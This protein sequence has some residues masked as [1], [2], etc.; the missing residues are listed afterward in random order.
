[1]SQRAFLQ[2][3]DADLHAA[4]ADAG[5]AET[6]FY[7]D[8]TIIAKSCRVYVN[9]DAQT[10][11]EFGEVSGPRVVCEIFRADVASPKA[12]ATLILDD[13]SFVL[14]AKFSED[15]SLSRWVVRRG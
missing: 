14:D 13:E 6:A 7:T 11:G 5:I 15:E 2:E 4:F 1:M 12:G 9:R 10:T 8:A 3:L